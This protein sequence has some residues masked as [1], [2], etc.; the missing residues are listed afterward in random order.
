MRGAPW[1]EVATAGLRLQSPDRRPSSPPTARGP[2]GGDRAREAGYC[3]R[4]ARRGGPWA[5]GAHCLA[6]HRHPKVALSVPE[7]LGV[8]PALPLAQKMTFMRTLAFQR[9][10]RNASTA[11]ARGGR[12]VRRSGAGRAD[13]RR[14]RRRQREGSGAAAC[15]FKEEWM[16]ESVQSRKGE[17]RAR[18]GRSGAPRRR[19]RRTGRRRR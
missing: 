4:S 10:Q 17:R 9:N 18:T 6:E 16:T 12:A 5:G 11:V 15:D 8:A 14:P 1:I 7:C 2:S 19:G 13:R 3:G